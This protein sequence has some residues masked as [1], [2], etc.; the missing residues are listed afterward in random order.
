MAEGQ[1]TKAD[2]HHISTIA[3]VIKEK[4]RAVGT[5][6]MTRRE[7]WMEEAL[8]ETQHCEDGDEEAEEEEE[9]EEEEPMLCQEIFDPFDAVGKVTADF[10][11]YSGQAGDKGNSD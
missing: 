6:R 7:Q 11:N 4:T 1:M 5:R 10:S 3:D 8:I 9:E 2:Q